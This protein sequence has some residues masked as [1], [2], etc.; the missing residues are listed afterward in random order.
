MSEAFREN[1]G[2]VQIVKV[3]ISNDLLTAYLNDERIISIPLK[4]F[5]KLHSIFHSTNSDLLKN[6]RISSSGYGIH[7]PDLDE[8]VSI[9]AFL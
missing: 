9:K 7:W 6:Y 4:R 5:Q 2:S 8:D 1:Q 3:E